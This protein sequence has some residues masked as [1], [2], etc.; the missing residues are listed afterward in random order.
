MSGSNFDFKEAKSQ[1]LRLKFDMRST[2]IFNIDF[3][4]FW[5]RIVTGF[6]NVMR[7]YKDFTVI[8]RVVLLLVIDTSI[9]ETG[10]SALNRIQTKARTRLLISTIR[11][12]L[13][14]QQHG[15]KIK[16]FDPAPI[17]EE[18]VEKPYVDGSGARG[19]QLKTMMRK[20]VK[21]VMAK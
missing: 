20:L 12:V 7:D 15:P 4:N 6:D 16:D 5:V 21:K 9:C 3:K 17:Y 10:Y 11:D 13:T 1:Y 18:W 2:P 14:T 8:T 19:R